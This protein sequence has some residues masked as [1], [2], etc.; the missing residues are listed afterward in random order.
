MKIE[1]IPQGTCSRR[2]EI[3]IDNGI[4]GDLRVDGGC[5]GN[6]KGVAALCRGRRAQE[7]ADALEGICCGAKSTSC[8]DQIA[9][10]LRSQIKSD[11][12]E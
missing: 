7:V 3:E 4:V 2:I 10:A 9:K 6:L 5:N 11:G 1:Y 8:P 12:N